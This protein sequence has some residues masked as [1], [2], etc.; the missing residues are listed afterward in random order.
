MQFLKTLDEGALDELRRVAIRC[1][2]KDTGKNVERASGDLKFSE[3]LKQ[4][5]ALRNERD[6]A[7][8][9]IRTFRILKREK[10]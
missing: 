4:Q 5:T 9:L 8:K 3:I 10:A 1:L 7:V 2:Q 6:A